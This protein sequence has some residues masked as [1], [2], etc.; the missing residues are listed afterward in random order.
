M[1]ARQL[2]GGSCRGREVHRGER[3]CGSGA[4]LD[5]DLWVCGALCS[6]GL[7]GPRWMLGIR[8]CEA[9][10]AATSVKF[11]LQRTLSSHIDSE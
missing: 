5:V 8:L 11:G 6:Q 2:G 10:T 7:W 9:A 1:V 4:R 3:L